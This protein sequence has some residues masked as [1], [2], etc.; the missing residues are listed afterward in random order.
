MR[1]NLLFH[2]AAETHLAQQVVCDA[3]HGTVATPAPMPSFAKSRNAADS[4]AR[5]DPLS[6]YSA[7]MTTPGFSDDDS[8]QMLASN[9][10]L[11]C[12]VPAVY[13]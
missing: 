10:A 12:P 7:L 9:T 6:P 4:M 8:L 11:L 5:H 1:R 13:A 3:S 2:P